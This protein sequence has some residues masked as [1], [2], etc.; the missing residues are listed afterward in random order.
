MPSRNT[1]SIDSRYE[2]LQH[3]HWYDG[4]AIGCFTLP[5]VLTKAGGDCELTGDEAPLRI[6]RVGGSKM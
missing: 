3:M 6:P 2:Y 5:P 4:S 1:M